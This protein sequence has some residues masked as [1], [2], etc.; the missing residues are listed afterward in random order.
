MLLPGA[1]NLK[2]REVSNF[3]NFTV[4]QHTVQCIVCAVIY[5]MSYKF[6]M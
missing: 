6:H 4:Y 1:V 3:Q 2:D 5:I